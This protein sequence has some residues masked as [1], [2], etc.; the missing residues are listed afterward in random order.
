MSGESSCAAIRA[1]LEAVESADTVT[2]RISA[3][4]RL[5]QAAEQLELELVQQARESGVRWSDI[6]ELYGTTK[7]GVQ[8]R[9]RRRSAMTGTS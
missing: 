1:A 9:F 5:R 4:R 6:G 8:Q 7:Q 2:A 3:G